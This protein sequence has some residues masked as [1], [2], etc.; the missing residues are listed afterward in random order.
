MTFS[1]PP[2]WVAQLPTLQAFSKVHKELSGGFLIPDCP[3]HSDLTNSSTAHRALGT[4]HCINNGP[5]RVFVTQ[6]KPAQKG[7]GTKLWMLWVLWQGRG[8]SIQFTLLP[9]LPLVLMSV[10]QPWAPS[11]SKTHRPASSRGWWKEKA[12]PPE[13][14]SWAS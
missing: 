2:H 10:A 1:N 12:W 13:M 8:Q 5:G 9:K 11:L 4:Q 6:T 7:K 3:S 14:E